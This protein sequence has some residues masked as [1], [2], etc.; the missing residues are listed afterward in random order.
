MEEWEGG[1]STLKV[2]GQKAKEMLKT[3]F[4]GR[5]TDKLMDEMGGCGHPSF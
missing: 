1:Q 2:S 5:N 4:H 3:V